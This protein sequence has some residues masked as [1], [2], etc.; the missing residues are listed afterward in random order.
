LCFLFSNAILNKRAVSLSS[1]AIRIFT[2]RG[3]QLP[4]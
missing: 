2:T 4:L 3:L 1:S